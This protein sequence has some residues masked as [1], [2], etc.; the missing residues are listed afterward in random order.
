MI[1]N[2]QQIVYEA[3][4]DQISTYSVYTCPCDT[5][6]MPYILI[7]SIITSTLPYS[8]ELHKYEKIDMLITVYDKPYSNKNCL[9][10]LEQMQETI[11]NLLKTLNNIFNISIIIET[12]HNPQSFSGDLKLSF[13]YIS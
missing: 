11:N 1:I 9:Q 2:I 4:R 8:Q 3:L 6:Q 5:M 7:R 10:T 13:Y 12:N